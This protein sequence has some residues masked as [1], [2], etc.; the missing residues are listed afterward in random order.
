VVEEQLLP[1]RRIVN[2]FF[3]ETMKSSYS[4]FIVIEF[5]FARVIDSH[6]LLK[7]AKMS[8]QPSL[9][10]IEIIVGVQQAR[11]RHAR[12]IEGLSPLSPP[13]EVCF[14]RPFLSIS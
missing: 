3:G 4:S 5:N 11:Y 13:V 10:Q 7:L 9:S 6:C 14:G 2:D 1:V 8:Q 12:T